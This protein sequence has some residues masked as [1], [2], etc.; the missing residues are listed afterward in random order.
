MI[1]R[2]A[3][4]LVLVFVVVSLLAGCG[5]SGTTS[6][7]APVAGAVGPLEVF[8]AASLGDAF[9]SEQTGFAASNPGAR[10][11]FNFGGSQLLVSQVQQGAPADVVATADDRTMQV[12]ADAGLLASPARVF[13]SN[14]LAIAVARGNPKG[15]R[16]LADLARPGIALVLAAPT[17]PVGAYARQAL[18]AAGVVTSPRSL[19]LDARAVLQRVSLGEA[20]AGIVYVTD[21]TSAS[22]S[23]EPVLIPSAY[24]VRAAYPIA[25]LKAAANPALARAF[26][27][28][29]LSTEGRARLSRFGFGAP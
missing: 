21:I 3:G 2:L 23:V 25:V 17:V 6:P 13:A 7:P 22:A 9:K 15:I 24:D 10:I 5:L 18:T 16:A 29:V 12:L 1:R 14:H 19:E 11:T 20:D 28:Y 27:A 26:V 8:A 4:G